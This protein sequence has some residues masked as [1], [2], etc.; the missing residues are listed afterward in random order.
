MTGPTATPPDEG[1]ADPTRKPAPETASTI[2]D[3]SHAAGTENLSSPTAPA[4]EPA[5]A[6]KPARTG[7]PVPA[8]EPAPT[9]DPLPAGTARPE[10]QRLSA[11]P[12]VTDPPAAG[13]ATAM[14]APDAPSP[15]R[16]RGRS[17]YWLLP[18]LAFV[19]GLLI[20]GGVILAADL[21]SS[22]QPAS[23]GTAP[24]ATPGGTDSGSAATTITVPAACADGL[25]R[26]DAA[27]RAAKDG[28][29][30][31]GR[32]DPSEVRRALE[33][34]QTLE[35]QIRDLAARCR[36]EVSSGN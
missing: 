31:I 5:S 25:D 7:D 21:G 11:R 14:P 34:L 32:L 28:L 26:A 10:G 8:G 13:R 4:G 35:P 24:G 2:E 19:G 27:T 3:T 33:R 29:G 18:A 15:G 9:G 6:G 22:D 23:T 12:A 36:V 30:G 16:T 1:S 20:G 17:L